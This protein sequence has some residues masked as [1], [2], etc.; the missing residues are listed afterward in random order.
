M[1]SEFKLKM[2]EFAGVLVGL[3][4]KSLSQSVAS[5]EL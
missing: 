1:Q 5:L 4:D 2:V 3:A